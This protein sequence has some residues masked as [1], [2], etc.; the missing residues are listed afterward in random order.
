MASI[1]PHAFGIVMDGGT[2]DDRLLAQ[3]YQALPNQSI[4][5]LPI[6][7]LPQ[8]WNP[9]HIRGRH[10]YWKDIGRVDYAG[11]PTGSGITCIGDGDVHSGFFQGS[12]QAIKC[13][14]E[15]EDYAPVLNLMLDVHHRYP[16]TGWGGRD[17]IPALNIAATGEADS[18]ASTVG[19]ASHLYSHGQHTYSTNDVALKT[20]TDV[21]GWD[22]TWG[23]DIRSTDHTGTLPRNDGHSPGA[24]SLVGLEVDLL[25]NGPDNP[26]IRYNPTTAAYRQFI[27][28]GG[29]TNEP[30]GNW[31]PD[32]AGYQPGDVI[33]ETDDHG[34]V[35]MF[36]VTHGGKTGH[37]PPPWRHA[38]DDITD[39][40]VGWKW[41]EPHAT[42]IGNG[43]YLQDGQD[44]SYG[45]F[46]STNAHYLNAAI[47]L[48]QMTCATP[49][50][51]A[52][53]RIPADVPLDLSADG[54]ATRQNRHTLSYSAT[55]HALEY[56]HD[57]K[58]LLQ[59]DDSGTLRAPALT[60]SSVLALPSL[61]AA[62]IRTLPHPEEGEIVNDADS[63][64]PAIYEKGRWYHLQLTEITP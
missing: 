24:F 51:C 58:T 60:L 46:L 7:L 36:V 53:L 27:Y 39:G 10:M 13:V 52:A 30:I 64:A 54:T 37:Q 16:V 29:G 6:G 9:P 44:V 50:L 17:E 45:S 28:L 43:I 1:D 33:K 38:A 2:E 31:A 61:H 20:Y 4:V 18:A 59:V 15:E 42:S 35:S 26:A 5:N 14:R 8:W 49:P 41:G 48:S 55:T 56:R 57:Q 62:Q 12:L 47:D 40:T 63:H 23:I 22:S 32:F 25:A 34:V 3:M 19:L 21:Y 11:F